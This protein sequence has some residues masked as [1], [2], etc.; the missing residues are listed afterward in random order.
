VLDDALEILALAQ[1]SDPSLN[2]ENAI[3]REVPD[4]V[5][6]S[7]EITVTERVYTKVVHRR[8]KYKVTNAST[9]KE[10][11]VTA[12]GALKLLPGSRYSVD[13]AISVVAGKF[14]NH[15]PYERQRKDMSRLGL[16]VPVMTLSRLAEHV[17]VHCLDVV[18]RI[19]L[20]IFG[21]RLA[22]HLDETRWPILKKSESNGQ[23][24]VLSNQAGSYYRF[25]PSRAGAI[26]DE[27]LK[28]YEGAVLTDKFSGYLHFR[29]QKLLNWGL[30]WS[31]ARREFFD[32]RAVYEPE[33]MKI[34]EAIDDLFEIERRA[35][36]WSE[37]KLLRESESKSKLEEI[38]VLL[39]DARAEF[40]DQDDFCKAA[41][42]VLSA[43]AE[44]TAFADD[45]RLPLSN[46]EAERA[47]RHAVL[48]R[49][50]F[51]GSKTINGADVAATLYSV[52]ESCKK[53]QLDPIDYM[54]YII[55]EN[56]SGR[57][58]LT[59]LRQARKLR[60]VIDDGKDENQNY[61]S[62][63]LSSQ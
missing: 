12:P 22:C 56:A 20:D 16:D 60:G 7:A 63:I 43:W 48:G 58:P 6:T 35:R 61:E 47:L 5:E 39:Q 2:P 25:E 17:S 8:Q 41:N 33:V 27:L 44:F 9:Q 40:F 1:K 3:V 57:V 31:H 29:S 30:C 18:E 45:I 38:K 34:V 23:M 11:I 24:W 53:V 42:Y 26:A 21:S 37:L 14:L 10:T 4:F 28:G 50:N 62:P 36:T 49:K 59:P 46:N 19:R 54:K 52:I 32:L 55:S 15:L 51:N 13:F